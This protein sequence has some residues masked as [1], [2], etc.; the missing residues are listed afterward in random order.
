MHLAPAHADIQR[1]D[2]WAKFYV[3]FPITKEFVLGITVV[4]GPK[5]ALLI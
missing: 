5:L 3:L 1:W 2:T 4:V